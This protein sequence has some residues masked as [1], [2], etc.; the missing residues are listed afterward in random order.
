LG[1]LIGAEADQGADLPPI[2]TNLDLAAE[3]SLQTSIDVGGGRRR[4]ETR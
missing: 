2:S 4:A 1:G 3:S